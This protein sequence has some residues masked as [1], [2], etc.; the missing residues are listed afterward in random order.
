MLAW[1]GD[2]ILAIVLAVVFAMADTIDGLDLI[3]TIVNA[4]QNSQWVK[5]HIRM[6]KNRIW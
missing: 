3:L 1:S 6:T 5:I 2:G 4:C